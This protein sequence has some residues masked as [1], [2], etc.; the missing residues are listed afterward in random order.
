MFIFL[1]WRNGGSQLR[2][3]QQ[4]TDD[5]RTTAHPGGRRRGSHR[6]L[7]DLTYLT[8]GSDAKTQ[9]TAYAKGALA[10]QTISDRGGHG[11]HLVDIA[12]GNK[13]VLLL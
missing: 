3:R 10:G 2:C 11:V 4:R 7:T 1:T 9:A 5:I 13:N 12:V 6:E 8:A